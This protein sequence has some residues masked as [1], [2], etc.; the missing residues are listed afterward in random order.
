MVSSGTPNVDFLLR[1]RN[2]A[3]GDVQQLKMSSSEWEKY[4][5]SSC[6]FCNPSQ[7]L[8]AARPSPFL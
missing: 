2:V 1:Y 7:S 8:A 5:W 6:L 3:E 4:P